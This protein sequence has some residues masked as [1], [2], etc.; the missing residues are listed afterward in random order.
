M[1]IVERI[2][3]RGGDCRLKRDPETGA[4]NVTR[5]YTRSQTN[6][7]DQWL[8]PQY[9]RAFAAGILLMTYASIRFS[10]VQR[11]RTSEC[12]SDSAH[13][14]LLESKTR[15][16]HR[17][18]WPWA[19]PLA[20]ITGCTDWVQ[21]LVVMRE[22]FRNQNG[23]EP[24]FTFP[25]VDRAW[26]LVSAD[27]APYST[28]RRKLAILCAHLGDPLGEKYTLRSPKNLF[29]TASSQMSFDQRGL[30]IIGHW[31]SASKTPER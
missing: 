21:P 24:M 1:A 5:D 15:K 27:S 31:S 30:N 19:C 22:A 11:V 4:G 2:D 7:H 23:S 29:P 16:P 25:R 6:C 14:A 12:N 9:K 3:R 13:G 10:D 26:R 17:M 20:G 28:T 8:F 18:F